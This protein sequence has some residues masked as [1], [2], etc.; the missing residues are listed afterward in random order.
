MSTMANRLWKVFCTLLTLIFSLT[1]TVA[2]QDFTGTQRRPSSI[3]PPVQLAP[4][5]YVFGHSVNRSPLI[6]YIFGHGANTTMIFGAFHNNEPESADVVLAL[7]DYLAANPEEWKGRTI[8]V[9]PVAN[10]DGRGKQSRLNANGVDL[11]RNFPGTWEPMAI[12]ARYNPGRKA[13]SEPETRAIMHLV[14]KFAPSKIVSVHQPFHCLN[15]NGAKGRDLAEVMGRHNG[16]P[17]KGDIGYP[18]PG[19][20]GE[21]CERKGIAIVTLEMPV[22]AFDVCW[23]QNQEALLAAIRMDTDGT[24]HSLD[25]AAL[26]APGATF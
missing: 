2:A 4:V 26:A 24:E 22:E 20:F 17:I 25:S 10:P 19:S 15:W 7:R 6:A 13:G 3:E 21:Y 18:T 8:V 23:R 9:I 14:E 12:A 5:K 16:Y 11:N 1:L